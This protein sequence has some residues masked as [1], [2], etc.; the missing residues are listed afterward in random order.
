MRY[1]LDTEFNGFGG[2]L[3]SLALVR[4]DGE[5][6]SYVFGCDAPTPWVAEHVMPHLYAGEVSHQGVI[7]R[8]TAATHLAAFLHDDPDALIICD[9]P[10]DLR[11]FCDLIVV[12]PGKVVGL[13]GLRFQWTP[14]VGPSTPLPGAVQHNAWWDATSLWS[15]LERL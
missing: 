9:W 3:I 10:E 8:A 7:D 5:S 6:V 11:H 1:Y 4:Q 12:G 2:A 14:N 15:A 13:P